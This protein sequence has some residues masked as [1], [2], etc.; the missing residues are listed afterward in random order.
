[1]INSG[2]EA[3]SETTIGIGCG[4]PLEDFGGSI[5]LNLGMAI[6][7]LN[8][9]YGHNP[10]GG[11]ERVQGKAAGYGLDLALH[12]RFSDEISVAMVFR[13]ILNSISWKREIESIPQSSRD[14]NEGLARIVV[15]GLA[16]TMDVA[17]FS[18][19]YRPGLYSDVNDRM[20]IGSEFAFWKVVKARLGLAQDMTG[21][22]RNRWVTFGVGID[23]AM[24]F[25]KPIKQF[26]FGYSLLMHDID[27]SPRVGLTIG[28]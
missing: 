1:M 8:A 2:D 3:Y 17:V 7:I 4:V 15:L 20:T 11:S 22:D 21:A 28:W 24:E 6:K 26:K 27:T 16:Y 14:Y 9:V 12:W 18:A 10:E 5:P 19:E 13:D 23:L 25:L